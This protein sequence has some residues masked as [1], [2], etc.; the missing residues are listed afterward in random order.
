[1]KRKS[2]GRRVSF[3]SVRVRNVERVL[4]VNEEGNYKLGLTWDYEHEE[5]HSIGNWERLRAMSGRVER[6]V[7][8]KRIAESTLL[9]KGRRAKQQCMDG[10]TLEPVQGQGEQQ[11]SQNGTLGSHTASSSSNTAHGNNGGEEPTVIDEW[12]IKGDGCIWTANGEHSS[13]VEDVDGALVRTRSG[14]IYKLGQ[15]DKNIMSVC[16][17]IRGEVDTS[18]PLDINTCHTLLYAE[19]IVYGEGRQAAVDAVNA[20]SALR[21]ALKFP[22][23]TNHHFDVLADVLLQLGV[24]PSFHGSGDAVLSGAGPSQCTLGGSSSSSTFPA[25]MEDTFGSQGVEKKEMMA[26]ELVSGT[27]FGLDSQQRAGDGVSTEESRDEL[28]S[29]VELLQVSDSKLLHF[30]QLE[31]VLHGDVLQPP[32]SESLFL[33]EV[34][35]LC[36]QLE[37]LQCEIISLDCH[38]VLDAVKRLSYMYAI[39]P[40]KERLEEQDGSKEEISFKPGRLLDEMALRFPRVER[41]YLRFP[42]VRHV[43]QSPDELSDPSLSLAAVDSLFGFPSVDEV[44]RVWPHIQYYSCDVIENGKV[45]RRELLVV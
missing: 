35:P 32:I 31:S 23:L 22:E 16:K 21:K 17:A 45:L 27:S 37:E 14:N 12:H 13:P 7:Q 29:S 26:L 44:R 5:Q 10:G 43:P 25:G 4:R 2:T 19:N 18:N 24:L 3:G 8:G 1:M 36:P 9:E 41:L 20:L 34:V 42:K 28:K 39:I 15:L 6:G 30:P 40:L 33:Q 11:M 38:L